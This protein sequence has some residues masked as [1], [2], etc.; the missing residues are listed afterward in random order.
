MWRNATQREKSLNSMFSSRSNSS[1]RAKREILWAE[2]R[3]QGV[4][5]LRSPL[6]RRTG[7]GD[8]R[9]TAVIPLGLGWAWF[10]YQD[11]WQR[12]AMAPPW[13]SSCV[14][15]P[16]E[17]WH[18]WG[19]QTPL[20]PSSYRACASP[21]HHSVAVPHQHCWQS[22]QLGVP[23]SGNSL[24]GLNSPEVVALVCFSV[25]LLYFVIYLWFSCGSCLI[26]PSSVELHIPSLT[27]GR[28]EPL[29]AGFWGSNLQLPK[30][31]L[32]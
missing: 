15:G 25:Y 11:S 4:S 2:I 12:I 31:P 27:R 6:H 26:H 30:A 16:T 18:T 9:G 7:T 14:R 20:N 8:G 22:C 21:R 29:G 19:Y 32:L 3:E 13:F 1:L 28:L 24:W 17:R 5:T 23:C 10:I